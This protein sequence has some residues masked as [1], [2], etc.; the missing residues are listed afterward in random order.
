[1]VFAN[2][3]FSTTEVGAASPTPVDKQVLVGFIL[4]HT[5]RLALSSLFFTNTTITRVGE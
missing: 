4:H 5:F 1:M 3:K 2:W